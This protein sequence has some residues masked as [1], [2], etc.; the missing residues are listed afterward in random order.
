MPEQFES[1]T[2]LLEL[3]IQVTV[4]V[5]DPPLQAELHADQADWL[6]AK[7]KHVDIVIPGGGCRINAFQSAVIPVGI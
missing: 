3:S 5:W 1:A 4:L 7:L 6:Q 2:I